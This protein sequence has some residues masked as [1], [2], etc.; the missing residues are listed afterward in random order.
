MGRPRGKKTLNR[1]IKVRLPEKEYNRLLW[2]A[3]TYA[4]GNLS[5]LIRYALE[6][7]PLRFLK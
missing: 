6:H 1:T 2:R 5:M 3:R 4:G 7:M